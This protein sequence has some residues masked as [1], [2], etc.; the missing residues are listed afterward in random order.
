MAE[1]QLKEEDAILDDIVTTPYKYGFTTDIE[2]EEF[3]KGLDIGVVRKI[4]RIK[5][6]PDFLLKFRE[7][8]FTSW[9]KMKSPK[10]SCLTFPEIDY[11]NIRYYSVPKTKQKLG[12]LDEVDPELLATFEKLGVS[13]NEQKMLA[14]VAVDAVFDSVSI[15][16][17]FKK[18]LQK[19]FLHGYASGC[20]RLPFGNSARCQSA[21]V[22]SD[23][24]SMGLVP[25]VVVGQSHDGSSSRSLREGPIHKVPER[26]V[27]SH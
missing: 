16:T 26:R 6:E 27:V 24:A 13:L 9:T 25:E 14:N 5:E 12:S 7:K 18:Q 20:N 1:K 22:G 15:G 23:L 17:T 3:E 2:T 10:W 21:L 4:S 11:N 19:N 8:A